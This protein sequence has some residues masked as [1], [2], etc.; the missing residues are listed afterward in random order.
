MVA[1]LVSE[2]DEAGFDPI[3]SAFGTTVQLL[4]AGRAT[5]LLRETVDPVYT[6]AASVG[7]DPRLAATIQVRSGEGIAGVVAERGEPLLGFANGETFISVPIRT[8]AGIEGVFNATDRLDGAEYT[9]RDMSLAVKAAAHIASLIQYGR[10]TSR[11]PV[12]GLHNRRAFEEMLQREAARSRRLGTGFAVVFLDLDNMKLINDRYGHTRGD[13][14]IRGVG[15]RIAGLLR[16]YD[17]AARYGGDEFVV[18]L[19]TIAQDDGPAVAATLIQRIAEGTGALSRA[20]G[21]PLS[22]STGA[23]CW[24]S[25]AGNVRQVLALADERMYADKRRRKGTPI[26]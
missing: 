24:P 10:Y 22:I 20:L 26:S 6:V 23:A 9:A 17:F 8:D 18:L 3:R 5:L 12:S 16:P 13:E 2:P 4:D 21:V 1:D 7:I 19:S 25:D 15:E 11:D 14:V